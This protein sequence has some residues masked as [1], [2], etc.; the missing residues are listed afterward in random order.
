[1]TDP[2]VV[3]GGTGRTGR[4]IVEQ[5]RRG[6]QS[7]RVM[8]RRADPDADTIVGSIA[9]V[10]DVRRAVGD[11]GAVVVIV[12]SSEDP[13]PN[14]PEEVHHRGVQ[15]VIAATRPG[16]R[17]VL[18]TQIYI[19]RPE[20]F[21]GARDIILARRRGEEALRASG[22][23]YTIVRP[24]WLTDDPGG[25]QAIRFEQGDRGDGRIARADVATVVVG[26]LSSSRSLGKT[27][28]IYDEPG[29]PPR[30]WDSVFARLSPDGS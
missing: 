8:A 9:D 21:E 5:L 29:P 17:I 25:T 3:I 18:V 10:G 11:A 7:V 14:G 6:A 13:G 22:R 23:P 12:E 4:L 28:E 15:N 24:S 19:T 20:M 2:A 27:F 26:A 30:D 16:S 1:M